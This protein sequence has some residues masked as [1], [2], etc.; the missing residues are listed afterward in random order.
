MLHAADGLPQL[1]GN[2]YAEYLR[3]FDAQYTRFEQPLKDALR[4]RWVID[5]AAQLGCPTACLESS[6]VPRKLFDDYLMHL[7][8]YG[9]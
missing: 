2:S 5:L 7:A 3:S 4:E 8:N 1:R 6:A 9:A